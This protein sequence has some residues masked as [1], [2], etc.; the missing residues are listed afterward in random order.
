MYIGCTSPSSADVPVRVFYCH[1][2]RLSGRASRMANRIRVFLSSNC[3]LKQDEHS[4][5]SRT[6]ACWAVATVPKNGA[7]L[8]GIALLLACLCSRVV[9]TY[10]QF[11]KL[12]SVFGNPRY[13]GPPY[14]SN[15]KRDHSLEK[16]PSVR[17]EASLLCLLRMSHNLNPCR[18]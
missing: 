12:W 13:M 5:K 16:S 10:G 8:F 17:L 9:S 11:S 14:N 2:I 6:H 4:M 18:A 1:R 7:Q 3:I 15:P